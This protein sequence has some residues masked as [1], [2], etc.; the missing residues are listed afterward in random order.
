MA[1]RRS[2]N[3]QSGRARGALHTDLASR[4][5]PRPLSP[6]QVQSPDV[7]RLL[8]RVGSFPTVE[9]P[10]DARSRPGRAFHQVTLSAPP[11]VRAGERRRV[12]VLP[13]SLAFRSPQR[14]NRCIRR[15]DRREVLFALNRA[16]YSG[17]TRGPYRRTFYSNYSC[18]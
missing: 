5:L 18:R 15:K 17:S 1:K 7:S 6:I 8:A 12:P 10:V 4:R 3:V 2:R 9:D 14:V 16:G 13:R 11:R